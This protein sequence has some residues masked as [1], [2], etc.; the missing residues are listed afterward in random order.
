MKSLHLAI[1]AV[2]SLGFALP[3]VA[4]K[5]G[6]YASLASEVF[7]AHAAKSAGDSG[8]ARATAAAA[9]LKLLE[10]KELSQAKLAYDDPERAKW[11][12]V[13][14]RGEVGG[15]RLGDLDREELQ[16]A[17]DFLATALSKQGYDQ[18]R[19]IMLADDMLLRDGEPR[20]GF[21]AENYWLAVFG[22][23][24]AK[25]PWGIQ[26]D[27][28]HVAIN[29]TYKG[30]QACYSPS[31]IGT[32][33]A[34]VAVGGKEVT[35]MAGEVDKAYKLVASLSDAQRT[36]A[37]RGARRGRIATAA[38][39]DGVVPEQVGL[40]C[41]T[42]D[43]KQRA[44]LK[45]LLSEWVGD[46]PAPAAEARM[47]ELEK[48]IDSMSFAW[49]GPTKSGS[50]VSYRIQGPTLIVEYACQDLGGNPLDHLHSMYRNPTNEY[51]KQY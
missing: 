36:K 1:T 8:A 17:C 6:K 16:A 30:E 5:K 21:G 22:E 46:L 19:A 37:I 33:P 18:A 49:N 44:L 2:V 39:K 35:V 45:D 51:G 27:G 28:H 15:V 20:P 12:N 13:P 43:K 34:K 9:F 11:T 10:P 40:E 23:P 38:G 29:V 14:P 47:A 32:Q 24:H 41:S 48:E 42:F 26:F 31:F 7:D 50:D 3:A 4:Q 25:T